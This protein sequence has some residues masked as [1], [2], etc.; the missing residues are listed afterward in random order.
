MIPIVF[1][2]LLRYV[3]TT[4]IEYTPN[5]ILEMVAAEPSKYDPRSLDCYLIEPDSMYLTH[6]DVEELHDMMSLIKDKYNYSTILTIINQRNME[7]T[8]EQFVKNLTSQM[9]SNFLFDISNTMSI[10]FFT[11]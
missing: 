1:L 8:A 3:L 9:S 2:Y 10:F 4:E 11:W 7:F 6:S 5:D